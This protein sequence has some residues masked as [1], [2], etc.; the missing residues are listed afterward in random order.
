MFP[1]VR[2]E[3]GVLK[4][5]RHGIFGWLMLLRKPSRTL[6][7]I[8]GVSLAGLAF[9]SISAGYPFI[10]MTSFLGGLAALRL[11][12]DSAIKVDCATK[13]LIVSR[14]NLSRFTHAPGSDRWTPPLPRFL[15]WEDT[16]VE[17]KSDRAALTESFIVSGPY[18][19]LK[20]LSRGTG[21]RY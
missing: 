10:M 11:Q 9:S 16:Y 17:V 6:F 7:L 18:V 21:M 3:A 13:D 19:L 5:R 1:S 4:F 2:S 15:R 20:R 12:D 8:G 14:M